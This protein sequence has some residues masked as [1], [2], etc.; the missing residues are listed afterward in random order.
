MQNNQVHPTNSQSQQLDQHFLLK[1]RQL[2]VLVKSSK[3]DSNLELVTLTE[4]SCLLKLP[5]GK[6]LQ[7]EK[8]ILKFQKQWFSIRTIFWFKILSH[9]LCVLKYICFNALGKI[10]NHPQK[11]F[12]TYR[13]APNSLLS[14]CILFF[15]SKCLNYKSLK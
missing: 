12:K 1:D 6:T 10:I 9:V 3:V 7:C 15:S 4:R 14:S 5:T 8:Y 2:L 11:E 13:E